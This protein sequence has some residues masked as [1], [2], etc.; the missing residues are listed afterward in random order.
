[1]EDYKQFCQTAKVYT[2]VHAK[3]KQ[4]KELIEM[5]EEE[6]KVMEVDQE[7]Q[8]FSVEQPTAESKRQ[9]RYQRYMNRI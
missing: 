7:A 8:Q 3:P 2:D 5:I 9:A 4:E 1:M 6:A